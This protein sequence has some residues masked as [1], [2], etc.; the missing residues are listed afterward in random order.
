MS[1]RSTNNLDIFQQLIRMFC[2][3]QHEQVQMRYPQDKRAKS[4][5]T[6]VLRIFTSNCPNADEMQYGSGVANIRLVL[7]KM[8]TFGVKARGAQVCGRSTGVRSTFYNSAMGGMQFLKQS[9]RFFQVYQVWTGSISQ[10]IVVHC[11]RFRMVNTPS[12]VFWPVLQWWRQRSGRLPSPKNDEG[13][14]PMGRDAMVCLGGWVVDRARAR[15]SHVILTVREFAPRP[16][17][18]SGNR[19]P[20]LVQQAHSEHSFPPLRFVDS[21]GD[22]GIGSPLSCGVRISPPILNHFTSGIINPLWSR[23]VRRWCPTNNQ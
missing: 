7:R 8:R 19:T 16:A 6:W 23:H 18:T 11:A 5:T 20:H 13:K 17:A 10:G 2:H 22:Y 14:Q 3:S 1:K 4:V 21:P 12:S 9:F 15:G